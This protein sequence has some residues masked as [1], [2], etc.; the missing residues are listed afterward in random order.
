M[1]TRLNESLETLKQAFAYQR[2]YLCLA[3]PEQNWVWKTPIQNQIVIANLFEVH[4]A[5]LQ[6][7]L[8][9]TAAILYSLLHVWDIDREE[10]QQLTPKC[11]GQID[12]A[13]LQ[14]N[15]KLSGSHETKQLF[16]KKYSRVESIW[17]NETL[18]H[19]LGCKIKQAP[20]QDIIA[21]ATLEDIVASLRTLDTSNLSKVQSAAQAL[22][23][24]WLDLKQ[25]RAAQYFNH[26]KN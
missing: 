2:T 4:L 25:I 10:Y 23:S 8:S 14:Q 26:R 5:N 21:L 13:W 12:I 22:G 17:N 1:K 20:S 11:I 7:D 16:L 3:L 19:Y 18:H 15:W 24:D 9:L 6:S